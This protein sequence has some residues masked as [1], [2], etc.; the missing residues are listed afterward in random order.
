MQGINGIEAALKVREM[1]PGCRILLFS[2]QTTSELLIE[3]ARAQNLEFELLAKPVHPS[4]LIAKV[5]AALSA[6]PSP[7]SHCTPGGSSG[8]YA[9]Q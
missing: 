7:P 2:G 6:R 3:S 8:G 1:L 4:E 5:R 9:T